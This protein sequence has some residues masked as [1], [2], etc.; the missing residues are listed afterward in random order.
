[1][2]WK[3]YVLALA[4]SVIV[5]ASAF[6][7][8]SGSQ[9]SKS[10]DPWLDYNDDGKISLSDLVMLAQAYGTTGN[11]AKN[12]NVTNWPENITVVNTIKW[13]EKL[14]NFTIPPGYGIIGYMPL[15]N[16][17]GYSRLSIFV[18]AEGGD[19]T[20]TVY[21]GIAFKVADAWYGFYGVSLT[22]KVPDPTFPTTW[23]DSTTREVIGPAIGICYRNYT[24][25]N[26]T[27]Y[28]GIYLSTS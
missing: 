21:L 12:V 23:Q 2:N 17:S 3:S 19:N 16:V 14:F 6:T 26:V 8:M 20:K 15:T 28:I 7:S 18:R 13:E 22:P 1:L 5:L 4:L 10:Y 25:Q 24:S 11:P 27:L 9:T